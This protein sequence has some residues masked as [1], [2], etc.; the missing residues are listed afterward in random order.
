MYSREADDSS[1]EIDPFEFPGYSEEKTHPG[2]RRC[3]SALLKAGPVLGL[4][5]VFAAV[6]A[7]HPSIRK[8]LASSP[9][10]DGL[11]VPPTAL[12]SR[13]IDAEAT[14]VWMLPIYNSSSHTIEVDDL[15]TNCAY[16]TIEPHSFEIAPSATQVVIVTF[17]FASASDADVEELLDG[18]EVSV[19]P[20]IKDIS[21]PLE[22]WNLSVDVVLP[23]EEG[24]RLSSA[25]S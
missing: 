12:R 3:L 16:A 20:E 17:N 6:I 15:N 22:G 1:R 8:H 13:Q 21:E 9:P 25:A 24:T 19:V 5:L 4:I 14:T 2:V 11:R 23:S 10:N 7:G 18:L